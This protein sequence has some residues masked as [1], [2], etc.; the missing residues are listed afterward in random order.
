MQAKPDYCGPDVKSGEAKS[1]TE[2]TE[3]LQALLF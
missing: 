3:V 1:R 2:S